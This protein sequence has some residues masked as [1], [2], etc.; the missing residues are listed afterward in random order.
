MAV[1]SE[2]QQRILDFIRQYREEN[3]YPPTI[4]EIGKAVGITST[5]V[6]KYNLERLQEKGCIG[7]SKEVSRGLR[8]VEDGSA[9]QAV[10]PGLAGLPSGVVQV[11]IFGTIS[12]GAPIAV[13]G[14]P[15]NPEETLSLPQ[16]LV[17]SSGDVYALR[18][19]GDSMV[20]ALIADGDWIVIRHQATAEPG[21][22]IV[23]WIKD[24]EETT[25][26]YYY[27]EHERVR[28]QPANPAYQPIFVPAAQLEIQGKVAAVVR[29]I[30]RQFR[31]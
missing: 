13:P 1:L 12:A 7:R 25:L 2:R 16:E 15:D 27:P 30:A 8:L 31:V 10:K 17:P 19:R 11:P 3:G 29:P 6:V 21:E 5:S 23:A 14:Q 22:M 24:R 18:V 4:R 26:K 20:D 9:G 28:L